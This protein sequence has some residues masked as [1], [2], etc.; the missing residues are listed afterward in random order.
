MT[1]HKR[2]K[3]NKIIAEWPKGTVSTTPWFEKFNVYRQLLKGY[4]KNNWVKCIGPGAYVLYNDKVDW[5]GAL[6]AIQYQLKRPVFIGSKTA[7]EMAGYRQ[8]IPIGEG[9]KITILSNSRVLLP[10]WFISAK[11]GIE[12]SAKKLNLFPSNPDSGITEKNIGDYKIRLSDPE[13]AILEM[14][15]HIPTQ[16]SFES[17]K[18]VMEGFMSPRIDVLQQLLEA[19]R[20]IKAKRLFL[21]LA[22]LCTLPW[23]ESLNVSKINLGS[24]SR[25]IAKEGKFNSKYKITVPKNFEDQEMPEI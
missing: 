17:A 19:C 14:L 24:G 13:R 23:L 4:E 12:I 15:D 8:N 2:N 20:S 6:Y 7:L 10:K 21:Y 1:R 22:E 25:V 5:T 18:H 11:W 3:L 16:H 9:Q